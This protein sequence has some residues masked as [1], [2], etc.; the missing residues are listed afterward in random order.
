M[1]RMAVRY[2]RLALRP[3]D[4]FT[5]EAVR[6]SGIHLCEEA[7]PEAEKPIE[8]YLLTTVEVTTLEEALKMVDYYAQRWRIEDAF[9]VLK[10]GCKV[11]ELSMQKAS[12]LHCA[13]T[14]Y[15]VMAWRP[16]VDDA[17][18]ARGARGRGPDSVY[19]HGAACA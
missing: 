2:R 16:A 17:I 1:A 3:T 8:W 14:I 12:S 18:G 5:G 15:A 4:G 13:I 11:E 10:S 6:V 9:R 19:G 7:P